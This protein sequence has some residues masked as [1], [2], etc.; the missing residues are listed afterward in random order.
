MTFLGNERFMRPAIYSSVCSFPRTA[1]QPPGELHQSTQEE[2]SELCCG[3]KGSG[4]HILFLPS[5]LM[6]EEAGDICH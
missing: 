2:C 4:F 1:A 6:L 3:N 5:H